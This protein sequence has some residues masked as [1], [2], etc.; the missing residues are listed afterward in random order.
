MAVSSG[1]FVL[2]P[3]LP[4]PPRTTRARSQSVLGVSASAR[5]GRRGRVP[6]QRL[7]RTPTVALSTLVSDANFAC[8][9]LQVD[10]WTVAAR[11]DVRLP[12]RR[13][14]RTAVFAR[15]RASRPI[16]THSSE[17]Q[18]LFD[19]PNAPYPAPLDADS[20]GAGREHARGLDELRG[21][22]RSVH[23]GRVRGRRST[24][25][26]ARAVARA[27]RNRRSSSSFAATHHCAFW[28]A[29]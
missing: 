6:A 5:R 9:A 25:S 26:S 10:R 13:R 21:D 15:A 22:W 24:A 1:T 4:S 8:P 28:A 16:A 20:G 12:V 29:G 3:G 14:H 18:Y 19:Q 11:A 2:A 7:P 27:R 23:S 17:I